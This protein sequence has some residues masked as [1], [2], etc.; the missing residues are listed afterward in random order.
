MNFLRKMLATILILS[1]LG[2][3][4]PKITLAAQSRL[5]AKAVGITEHLPE[6]LALPEEEI[7]VEEVKKGKSRTWLWVLGGAVLVGIIAAA[8]GGGGGGGNSDGESIDDP[9]KPTGDITVSW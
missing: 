2:L 5:F 1:V 6:I 9:I 7:P 8:A 4:F 3:H